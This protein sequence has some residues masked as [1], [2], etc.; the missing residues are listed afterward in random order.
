MTGRRRQHFGTLEVGVV[1]RCKLIESNSGRFPA[2]DRRE[3]M[4]PSG[5]FQG[6]KSVYGVSVSLTAKAGV[7]GFAGAMVER[8]GVRRSERRRRRTGDHPV[9]DRFGLGGMSDERSNCLPALRRA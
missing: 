1:H 7:F 6:G 8:E 4:N 3:A 5:R 9:D 2:G